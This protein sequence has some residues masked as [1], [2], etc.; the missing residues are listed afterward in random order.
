MKPANLGSRHDM[1]WSIATFAAGGT[2]CAV[3]RRRQRGLVAE[4]II[5]G[6]GA[7]LVPLEEQKVRL[8]CVLSQFDISG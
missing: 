6:G 4:R 1:I 3:W 5:Q 8:D 2:I 7:T